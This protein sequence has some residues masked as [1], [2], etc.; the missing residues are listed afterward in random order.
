MQEW[1]SFLLINNKTIWWWGHTPVFIITPGHMM[2][3]YLRMWSKHLT[4]E[5]KSTT[6]R[7]LK[8]SKNDTT[9]PTSSLVPDLT[10]IIWVSSLHV[11][12]AERAESPIFKQH[13]DL[14][15]N[16][17]TLPV[18]KVCVFPLKCMKKVAMCCPLLAGPGRTH[19]RGGGWRRRKGRETLLTYN[20]LTQEGWRESNPENSPF[21]LSDNP[22]D[23]NAFLPL[24]I[25]HT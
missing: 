23:Q 1:W 3:T 5:K 11:R 4:E 8:R 17:T 18:K 22:N 12:S 9:K 2:L 7:S 24:K 15:T 20:D 6:L 19:H 13:T 16:A 10:W 21:L 25:N 14:L